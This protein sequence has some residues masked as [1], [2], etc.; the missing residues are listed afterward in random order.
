MYECEAVGKVGVACGRV[1]AACRIRGSALW[2]RML[3]GLWESLSRWIVGRD[4]VGRQPGA[5]AEGGD[6][7]SGKVKEERP[8]SGGSEEES[9]GAKRTTVL[10][11]VAPPQGLQQVLQPAPDQSPHGAYIYIHVCICLHNAYMCTCTNTHIYKI[12]I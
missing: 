12:N 7:N 6:R 5:E 2:E 1:Q 9:T 10:I 4:M 11:M 8:G 3:Q